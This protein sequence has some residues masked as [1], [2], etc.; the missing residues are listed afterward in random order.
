M[1]LYIHIIIGVLKLLILKRG[2]TISFFFMY[3]IITIVKQSCKRFFMKCW[4]M[5]IHKHTFFSFTL[6]AREDNPLLSGRHFYGSCASLTTSSSI[7]WPWARV[8]NSHKNTKT[9]RYISIFL[10]VLFSSRC[11]VDP[12]Y[13]PK[14]VSYRFHVCGNICRYCLI[15]KT[16]PSY[17]LF[18]FCRYVLT[19]CLS[20]NT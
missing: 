15:N 18:Y 2:W 19:P 1:V 12:L 10:F 16:F 14:K 5:P 13:S 11:L 17:T 7:L 4:L 20:S 8:D 3:H 9:S 6:V